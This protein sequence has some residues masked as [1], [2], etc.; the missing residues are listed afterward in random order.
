VV[1]NE[2]L[3][4]ST[5]LLTLRLGDD[6]R[7]FAFVPGQY[8]AINFY[9]GARPS[10]ARCFSIVS[11]PTEAGLL[12]F[13]I[14]N[15]GHYTGALSRIM[16]GDDVA[17]RGPF[18]GFVFDQ[19]RDSEAVFLAGGIGITPFI[20]M[21]RYL[22]KIEASNTVTLVYSC[23]NQD[24]I[25]FVDELKRL[26]SVNPNFRVVFVIGQGATDRLQGQLVTTGFISPELIDR[27]VRG[28]LVVKAFYICGPPPFMKGMA[29]NLHRQGVP[30][31]HVL[32]EA[33]GQGAN[34][35]TGKIQSWPFNVYV[36]GA[37]S[38]ALAV[39]PTGSVPSSGCGRAL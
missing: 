20:S 28:M 7:P 17:V 8:A 11:S 29:G 26:S 13:S 18:G 3:T 35:Q 2:A 5:S 15:G 38:L 16:P 37:V 39:S 36:L 14:R 21:I 1:S 30:E 27:V 25:P 12:Q 6:E 24:D 33:F 31:S 23:R 34:R 10:A 22:T 4:P 32:T 9:Q 19:A